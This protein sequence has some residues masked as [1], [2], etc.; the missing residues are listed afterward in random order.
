MVQEP[1]QGKRFLISSINQLGEIKKTAKKLGFNPCF[2]E[3]KQAKF[4]VQSIASIINFETGLYINPK[5]VFLLETKTNIRCF[6]IVVKKPPK[7]YL[8]SS[9]EEYKKLKICT[10]IASKKKINYQQ[11]ENMLQKVTLSSVEGKLIIKKGDVCVVRINDTEYDKYF[12]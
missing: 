12:F 3:T 4:D 7:V 5:D 8:L 2:K 9:V 10:K 6:R 1:H 11:Y